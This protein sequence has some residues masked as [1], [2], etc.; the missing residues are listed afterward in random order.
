MK[1]I[2]KLTPNQMWRVKMMCAATVAGLC[3]TTLVQ[4]TTASSGVVSTPVHQSSP[5]NGKYVWHTDQTKTESMG[6][7][8]SYLSKERLC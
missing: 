7:A 4:Q 5:Y 3:F 2:R 8:Q 6:L 1:V